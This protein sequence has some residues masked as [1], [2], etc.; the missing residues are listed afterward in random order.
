MSE[1]KFIPFQHTH[2]ALKT[3]FLR[4]FEKMIDDRWY[5]LGKGLNEFEEKWAEYCGTEYSIGVGNGFDAI[6]LCLKSLGI[7][8]GDEVIVPAHTFAATAL[9][10]INIGAK[11]I[12][13]DV[14]PKTFCIDTENISHSIT[15]K[16]K[17]ILIVHIY[18]NP[19]EMDEILAISEKHQI[20]IIEDNAQAHGASYNNHKT[21]SFGILSAVSFYPIKNLGALGDGGA[22]NTNSIEHYE[23][24]NLLRNYGSPDK[25]EFKLAGINSRLD[26]IQALLLSIQLDYLDEWNEQRISIAKIYN[27][28]LSGLMEV[29]IMEPNKKGQCVYHIY[30]ILCDDRDSL[31]SFLKKSKIDTMVHY[32]QP[33]FL[34]N[35]F[36][37]LQHAEGDFPVSERIC[38]QEL[39][40]P[41]YPGL[42]QDEANFVCDKIVEF[43]K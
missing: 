34:E 1:V 13:V 23:K 21:G 29:Q 9:P 26:E 43:F 7:K 40:L 31:R 19:C 27:K 41:I 39:S 38:K 16:T 24:I 33:Y 3:K 17:A 28:R 36:K 25:H 32:P 14:N 22:V 4:S 2:K 5:I 6:Y 37:Q 30:P 8:P 35:A 42:S 10:I 11:P 18:G 15:E 12:L 20:P